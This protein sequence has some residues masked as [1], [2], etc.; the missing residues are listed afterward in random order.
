MAKIVRKSQG[1]VSKIKCLS[2]PKLDITS[3]LHSKCQGGI[4]IRVYKMDKERVA[5]FSQSILVKFK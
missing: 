4:H 3:L 5:Y 1:S 2:W